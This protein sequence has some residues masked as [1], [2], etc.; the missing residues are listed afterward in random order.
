MSPLPVSEEHLSHVSCYPRRDRDESPVCVPCAEQGY[1]NNPT[2]EAPSWEG[3]MGYDVH[4]GEIRA[5]GFDCR[6]YVT[7]TDTLLI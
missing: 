4:S 2:T 1:Q 7:I 5:C 3:L 6:L